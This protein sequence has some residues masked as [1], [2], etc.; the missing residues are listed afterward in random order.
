MLSDKKGISLVVLIAIIVV[1]GILGAG[2]VS[3]MSSKMRSYPIEA[4]S[5]E[6]LC[7]ANAG[8]E[9]SIRYA[10]DKGYSFIENPQSV[11]PRTINLGRGVVTVNYDPNSNSL[12]ST[13]SSGLGKREVRLEGFTGYLQGGVSLFPNNLPCKIRGQDDFRIPILNNTGSKIYI[14]RIDLS[15]E[16]KNCSTCLLSIAFEEKPGRQVLVYSAENDTRC[17]EGVCPPCEKK[18]CEEA[19]CKEGKERCVRIPDTRYATLFFNIVPYY[20]MPASTDTRISIILNLKSW[21]FK[22]AHH[23]KV[24][25]KDDLASSTFYVSRFTIDPEKIPTCEK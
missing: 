25:W 20:E 19:P 11:F 23:L 7:L 22:V 5:F 24:F 12:T 17:R 4:R 10:H 8:I 16:D 21:N 13:A 9:F 15:I 14:W 3:F 6:A 18:G 2:V 1:S